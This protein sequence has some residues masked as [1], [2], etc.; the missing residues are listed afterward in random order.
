MPKAPVPDAVGEFLARPNPAVIATI[1]P[2]G[3]PHTAATWYVWEDGRVLVNMDETRRRLDYMRRDPRVS[4]T[5][6]WDDEWYRQVTLIGEVVSIE[7]DPDLHDI[8]RLST[9]YS[10]SPFGARHQHRWSAWVRVDRWF[11]W[12]GGTSWPPSEGA[13]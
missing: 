9:H 10:G 2:D 12:D 6:L 7:P 13:S 5:A 4:L 1:R 11:G 3:F 8:D